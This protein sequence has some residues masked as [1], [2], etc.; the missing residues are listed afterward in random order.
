MKKTLTL[1]LT[2][3]LLL[4]MTAC[5][6][7]TPEPTDAPVETATVEPTVE[8]TPEPSPLDEALE[9]YRNIAGQASAYQ[10]DPDGYASPNG[11]YRYAL[12]QMKP[13]DTVPTLLLE[14]G[15][16]D[17][18]YYMRVFQYDPATKTLHQPTGS[19]MEGTAQTG[20]YRGGIGMMA[21]GNGLRT[22]EASGGT[23][24]MYIYR[25]TIEGNSLSKVQ[26]WE[27]SLMDTVPENLD[28]VDIEWHDISDLSALGGQSAADTQTA[29]GAGAL[30]TDGNR[31]V[32]TGTM[33]T[34]S[35]NEVLKLQ[36]VPDPNPGASSG[37]NTTYRLIVLDTPKTM[38]LMSG[39]GDGLTTNEASIINVSYADGLDQYVG[40]HVVFSI[41]PN[42]TYWPS[43]TSLPLGEPG[44]KD[45][46]I[47]N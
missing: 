25:T 43:D 40:Q 42:N 37:K 17:Y 23:G 15:T 24:A 22:A 19:L 45:V 6:K 46:H 13:E 10:Y 20:G 41:D 30:P 21:D 35:Y 14:Q 9:H 38:N 36:G 28:F 26:V 3:A 12:V 34:Y 29:A 16:T 44:T 27:G 7:K 18:M 8:P 1:L 31:I 4:T 5:G 11:S 2:A 39:A 33:G 32:L 47:L